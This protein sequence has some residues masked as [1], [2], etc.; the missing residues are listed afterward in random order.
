MHSVSAPIAHYEVM[1]YPVTEKLRVDETLYGTTLSDHFRWLEEPSEK[2]TEWLSQQ[3]QFTLQEIEAM[4]HVKWLT[5]RWDTLSRYNDSTPPMPCKEGT[6]HFFRCKTKEQ[7]RWVY[8]TQKTKEAKPEICVDPNGW[9]KEHF[10]DLISASHD[11]RYVAYGVSEGGNENPVI[12]IL[13]LETGNHLPD[14]LDGWKIRSI[15]W[16]PENAG[17]FYSAHPLKG[18]V[19]E[20][21]EHY[22]NSAYYH[23]LGTLRCDDKK[24][25]GSNTDK[26]CYH[27]AYV[28]E[29]TLHEVFSCS[30][31]RKNEVYFR[32]NNTDEPLT[33]LVKGFLGSY[34]VEF[35]KDQIYILTDEQADMQQIFVASL[36]T[37]E[38]EKWTLLV[39][40]KEKSKI[41][42]CKIID[43]RLFVNRLE[44]AY[45]RIEIYD[46][47]GNFLREVSLPGIG[48]ASF[49][50]YQEARPEVR[51]SY[52]SFFH[53]TET[54]E[55]DFANDTL[56]S[57]HR[58]PIEVD[59][60]RFET[61]QV[62]VTSKDGTAVTMFLLAKKNLVLDGSNPTYL[63]GYGGFQH[64]ETPGF[65][66]TYLLWL[67]AGGVVAIPNLRGGGEYGRGWHEAGIKEK[68]QN[69]FDD[70]IASAEYLIAEK[71]TS[72]NK[73]AI[74][75]GSNG[76]LL[77][78]AVMTQRPDLFRAVLCA[79][80]LLDMIHYHKWGLAKIWE[81]EYGTSESQEAFRYLLK[82]SPYHNVKDG[83]HYPAT[84]ITVGENDARV[85]PC[86]A[87]KMV[88]RLQEANA[89]SHPILLY[90]QAASGHSGAA[91]LTDRIKQYALQHAFLMSQ[92]GIL[93]PP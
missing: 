24:V 37:P 30:K 82:Y 25:F 54:F 88:A 79:V 38:R 74:Q 5:E 26:A 3:Q 59:T 16:C 76:G 85:N 60:S 31:H 66:S 75:G 68:K 58:T 55:Y 19:P 33:P 6:R 46:L 1:P 64:S 29:D 71:Y 77:V 20:G 10:L 48:S 69:V 50:G 93:V 44:N 86:H 92:L 34:S 78:G 13:D 51:I 8:Y 67:E 72:P 62:R 91:T 4:P 65:S 2:T 81:G 15:S 53:P 61:Q 28:T 89:S 41:T 27:T 47:K 45:T 36:E 70:F 63:T 40:E 17:F 42:Q 39:P 49:S 12:R 7:D 56:T 57:I 84:M 9:P 21:E 11:G 22:W 43:G 32:R 87:R 80:P 18:T 90:H 52:S 23:K 35:Y 83:T 14:T 73:L